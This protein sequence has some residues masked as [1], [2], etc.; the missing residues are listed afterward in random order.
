[1]EE[2]AICFADV[3]IFHIQGASM[4]KQ[5]PSFTL[6]QTVAGADTPPP[7]SLLSSGCVTA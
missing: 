4:T 7:P 1:M 2:E 5:R 6:K 3:L